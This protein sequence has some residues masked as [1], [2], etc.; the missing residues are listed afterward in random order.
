LAQS[1]AHATTRAQG[2][3]IFIAYEPN[4]TL[5]DY[6]RPE[7]MLE[8]G[9]RSTGEPNTVRDVV[10]DAAQYHETLIFPV[11][12]PRVMKP[13]RTFWEKA[14][15]IH[16]VCLQQR[17]RGERFARHWHDLVRLDEAGVA[18]TA[19]SDREIAEA[20]ARHKSMFFAE[21][22]STKS[23]IDYGAA[24]NGALRLVPNGA[25]H[26]APANDYE[27]MIKDGLLMDEAEPFNQLMEKCEA[28]EER[29]NGAAT[30]PA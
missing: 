4:G 9:A 13:E 21:N 2:D 19:L 24:V 28:I 22:D 20:V 6:V 14:T 25:A 3:R 10:C 18:D 8:F 29:A 23:K 7:V 16:V 26:A 12:Q 11:A 15:A 27:A 1:D 5:S 17:L 30:G